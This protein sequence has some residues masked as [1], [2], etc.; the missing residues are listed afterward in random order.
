MEN[1]AATLKAKKL[2]ATPQRVAIFNEL[3]KKGGHP[4]AETIYNNIKRLYPTMSLATVYKTLDTLKNH[5]LINEINVGDGS[6]RYDANM[7]SHAY[8]ICNK[9][10][11]ITDIYLENYDSFID[12]FKNNTS[13]TIERESIFLYG[14]C[15]KCQ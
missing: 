3:V 8:L 15:E 11:S 5:H 6:S 13:F 2:K 12:S 9:C 14:T 10:S 4:S 1:I 7:K